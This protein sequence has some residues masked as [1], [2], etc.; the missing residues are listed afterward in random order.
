M[1]GLA[2]FLVIDFSTLTMVDQSA[3]LFV[4]LAE[5]G[6]DLSI[7]GLEKLVQIGYDFSKAPSIDGY[8]QRLKNRK[9][10]ITDYCQYFGSLTTVYSRWSTDAYLINPHDLHIIDNTYCSGIEGVLVCLLVNEHQDNIKIKKVFAFFRVHG[11]K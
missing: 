5:M 2:L 8:V 6:L 10:E 9:M 7:C 1:I 3:I 4:E 11:H